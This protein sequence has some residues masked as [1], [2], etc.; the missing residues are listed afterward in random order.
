MA[1]PPPNTREAQRRRE[2]E[3]KKLDNNPVGGFHQLAP[4]LRTGGRS[5]IRVFFVAHPA[6]SILIRK[7]WCSDYLS[8]PIHTTTALSVRPP[9]TNRT[10]AYPMEAAK[11]RRDLRRVE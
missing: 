6:R 10:V 3:V 9:R 2:R 8:V 11:E 5:I 4:W 7:D 1:P